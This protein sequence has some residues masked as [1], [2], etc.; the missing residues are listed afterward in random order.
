M[1]LDGKRN[2][3][4]FLP[5]FRFALIP[6]IRL[7]M[8]NHRHNNKVADFSMLISK[9]NFENALIIAIF[10]K[11]NEFNIVFIHFICFQFFFWNK[12]YVLNRNRKSNFLGVTLNNAFHAFNNAFMYMVYFVFVITTR[13]LVFESFKFSNRKTQEKISSIKLNFFTLI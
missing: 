2:L 12:V 8:S 11:F 10:F 5:S 6:L 13:T 3:F 4:H 7:I 9:I 1:I